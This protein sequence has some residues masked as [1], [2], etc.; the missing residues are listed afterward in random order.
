[1]QNRKIKRINK[2]QSQRQRNRTFTHTNCD[3]KSWFLIVLAEIKTHVR[4]MNF[5]FIW[6]FTEDYI[7][8]KLAQITLN[9]SEE[10]KVGQHT[11]DFG[12]RAHATKYTSQ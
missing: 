6:E 12:E 4:A 8:G 10:M 11:C 3:T 7:P 5:S 1:M 2:D 9:F